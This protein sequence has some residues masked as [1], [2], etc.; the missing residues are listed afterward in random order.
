MSS[1]MDEAGMIFQIGA[2][3]VAITGAFYP[4]FAPLIG[5]VGTFLTGSDTS[6]NALFGNLQV[7]TATSLNLNP[8]LMAASNSSCESSDFSKAVFFTFPS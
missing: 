5:C 2:A 6:A 1:L 3:L 4:L 8:V 7:V